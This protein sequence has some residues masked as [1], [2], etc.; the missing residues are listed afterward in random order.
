[1]IL[2][3]SS[4]LRRS[5]SQSVYIFKD[6]YACQ[7]YFED[8]AW[9]ATIIKRPQIALRILARI[10]IQK[11]GQNFSHCICGKNKMHIDLSYRFFVF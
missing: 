2:Q 3:V 6:I 8:S 1:M 9:K 4:T 5:Q 11:E 10:L 7:L